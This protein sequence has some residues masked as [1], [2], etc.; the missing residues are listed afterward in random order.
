M[1]NIQKMLRI[2]GCIALFWG[3]VHL[4]STIRLWPAPDHLIWFLFFTSMGIVDIILS[5]QS[6]TEE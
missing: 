6:K 3:G 5:Q 1:S 4:D 2:V